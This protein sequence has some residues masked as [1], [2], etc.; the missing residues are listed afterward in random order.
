MVTALLLTV[1]TL[2]TPLF[3][4]PI[5]LPEPETHVLIPACGLLA[6]D[7]LPSGTVAGFS[8]AGWDALERGISGML[9]CLIRTDAHQSGL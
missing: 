6:N 2:H 5:I 1:H 7:L 9:F 8:L 3:Y 4:L